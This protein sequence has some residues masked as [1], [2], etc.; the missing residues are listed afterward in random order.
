MKKY[1]LISIICLLAISGFSQTLCTLDIEIVNLRSNK[2]EVLIEVYDTNQNSVASRK[3]KIHDNKCFITID[4]LSGADYAIQ[5][6]HDENSNGKFDTNLIGI[7]LEGYGISNNAYGTFG[8]SKFNEWLF[9]VQKQTK[10][11]LATKY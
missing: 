1:T 10:V 4:S 11:V 3:V 9:A 6:M 5:Y 2:G 8:P 7:P